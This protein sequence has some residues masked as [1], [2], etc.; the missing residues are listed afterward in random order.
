MDYERDTV[1]SFK[2]ENP[3][4]KIKLDIKDDGVHLGD[5]I[6][7]FVNFACMLGFKEETVIDFMRAYLK[8]KC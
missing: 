1:V 5:L 3:S 2:Y 8:E 7:N 6:E 4:E